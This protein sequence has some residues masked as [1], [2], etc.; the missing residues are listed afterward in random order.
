MFGLIED[1][2]M[3]TGLKIKCMDMVLQDGL[4]GDHMKESNIFF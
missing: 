3:E 1:N 2:I 4:M